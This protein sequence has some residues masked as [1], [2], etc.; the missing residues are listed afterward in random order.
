LEVGHFVLR[1]QQLGGQVLQP[2]LQLLTPR[3]QAL[4]LGLQGLVLLLQLLVPETEA[5][6]Q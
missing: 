4:Q 1:L 3:L 5:A 6:V 2:A